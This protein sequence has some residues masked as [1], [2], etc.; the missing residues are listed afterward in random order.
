MLDG[1]HMGQDLTITGRELATQDA[2]GRD[3]VRTI[4]AERILKVWS[5]GRTEETLRGYLGDLKHYCAWAGH[6]VPAAAIDALLKSR[7]GEANELVLTYRAQMLADGLAPATVNRRLS[8]LR[9]LVEIA[10]TIGMTPWSLS[11]KGVKSESY[12][13]TR[14][15]STEEVGKLLELV[16]QHKSEAKRRRD[17]AIIL[18]MFTNG[19]RR[20][21][22]EGLDLNHFE[23]RTGKLS[24][25]GKGRLERELVTLA[26]ATRKA[27]LGWIATRGKM[28][29][30]L[31]ITLATGRNRF[32]GMLSRLTADGVHKLMQLWG[33]ELGIVLRPHGLRHSCVTTALEETNGNITAA[34]R[35]A[36]HRNPAVTTKYDDNR[37]DIAGSTAAKVSSRVAEIMETINEGRDAE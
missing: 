4:D 36:R 23:P 32:A 34:M 2:G 33:D 15:P 14:G 28:P 17:T 37:T 22:V 29:G 7:Q 25:M 16:N 26:P 10:Q 8:A 21:E 3:L 1:I 11:I 20:G 13:D 12:R 31:F 18:L 35:L 24:V 5:E 27:L 30:P 19:I 9:S 6:A